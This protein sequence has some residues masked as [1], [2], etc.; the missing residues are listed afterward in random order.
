MNDILAQPNPGM[1]TGGMDGHTYHFAVCHVFFQAIYS[2]PADGFASWARDSSFV[3]NLQIPLLLL[4]P[5]P[6]EWQHVDVPCAVAVTYSTLPVD[7]SISS[8]ILKHS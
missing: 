2:F 6:N 7:G 3:H 5:C 1:M 4:A 8:T